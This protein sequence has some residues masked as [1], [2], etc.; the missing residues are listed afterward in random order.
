MLSK[1]DRDGSS[2]RPFA[3]IMKRL[4]D[5]LISNADCLVET[6]GEIQKICD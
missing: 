6:L 2:L 1:Q 3:R 5:E 4:V